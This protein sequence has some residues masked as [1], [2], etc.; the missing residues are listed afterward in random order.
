MPLMVSELNQR[1]MHFPRKLKDSHPAPSLVLE[2]ESTLATAYGRFVQ[3]GRQIMDFPLALI[4]ML[5]KTDVDDIA[6]NSIKM[7]YASQ[8][9]HFGPRADLDAKL[10]AIQRR[11]VFLDFGCVQL[12]DRSKGLSKMGLPAGRDRNE[13]DR[14][15]H[16]RAPV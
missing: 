15:I 9:L 8:Y 7:P 6:L 2:T 1:S 5:A 14:G 10:D 3:A 13:L 11:R 16:D 12:G 4:E